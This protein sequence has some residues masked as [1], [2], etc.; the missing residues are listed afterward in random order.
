MMSI[1]GL[2]LLMTVNVL[3]AQVQT[4]VPCTYDEW[5]DFYPSPISCNIFY[6]CLLSPNSE[7]PFSLFAYECPPELH[8]NPST[9]TCD[10]PQN[11]KPP[12]TLPDN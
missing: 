10:W 6:I 2:L 9:W 4:G 11:L 1:L 3:K 7:Y 8:F 12:C 5:G